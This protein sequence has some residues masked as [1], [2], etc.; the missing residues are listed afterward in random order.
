MTVVE[1]TQE[2]WWAEALGEADLL[3]PRTLLDHAVA[4][5]GQDIPVHPLAPRSKQPRATDWPNKA[6]TDPG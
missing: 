4:Y 5:T 2:E 6:T 1:M 3:E